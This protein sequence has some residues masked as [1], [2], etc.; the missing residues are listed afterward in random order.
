MTEAMR[1][2]RRMSD[3]DGLLWTIEK[4][5]LLRSTIVAVALLDRSPDRDRL[6]DRLERATRLIPRMRQRVV[7]APLV[8]AP[9]RWVVDANFDLGYHVRWMRAP[10]DGSRRALLDVVQPIAMQ[11]F[12]RARPLWEFT[13]VDGLADGRAALVQKIH[14]AITDGVGGVRMAL[15]LLDLERDP[16][17]AP[18]PMPPAPEPEHVRPFGLVLDALAHEQRRQLGIARR[19]GGTLAR[20]VLTAAMAPVPTARAVAGAAASAGRLLAPVFEPLSPVMRGRSLTMR[21][22]T[23]TVPLDELKAAAKAVDGK[24]NDAFV[25]AVAGGLGRY[26]ERHG[27]PVEQLRMTMPIN[28]RDDDTAGLAGTRF[29]PARF[30][31]PIAITDPRERMAVI[32]DLVSRERAEPA[33]A[34]TE[35]I[36][37]VLSRLPATVTTQV[38]GSML[39]GIDFV[40]TNVPGSPIPVFLAGAALEAQFAFAPLSGSAANIALMSYCDEVHVGVNVDAAAVPDPDVVTACLHDGF[41]EIRKLA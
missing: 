34:L 19:A 21:F 15:M 10:G 27:A 23:I 26:H 7:S 9:P 4:D 14:H 25:A 31:V 37:G 40:S 5:P 30:A 32:R 38:F 24:L 13:V 28:I 33:L 1:F 41:D 6:L 36:A 12:D 11:G 3:M 18:E 17:T 20:A 16:A 35:P 39:K 22:D 2:E 29:V 8:G